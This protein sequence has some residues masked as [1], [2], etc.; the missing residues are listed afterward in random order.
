[1][2][3]MQE[4][5]QAVV[6]AIKRNDVSTVERVVAERPGWREWSMTQAFPRCCWQI[7]R[8]VGDCRNPAT[9]RASYGHVRG[10]GLR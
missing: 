4:G 5:E 6:E 9:K 7:L 1:M 8:A 3:R 10:R 2:T